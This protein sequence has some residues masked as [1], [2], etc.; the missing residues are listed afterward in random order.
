MET[1]KECQGQAD[2]LQIPQT[3][4]TVYVTRSSQGDTFKT[5]SLAALRLTLGASV[6]LTQHGI[7]LRPG[8]ATRPFSQQAPPQGLRSKGE[9]RRE[10]GVHGQRC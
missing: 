2:L 8:K 9:E 3:S 7:S 6:G 5:H 1:F 10:I 4:K